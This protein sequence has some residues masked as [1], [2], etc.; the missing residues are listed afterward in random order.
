MG[1]DQVD[2]TDVSE[3]NWRV[4]PRPWS[5]GYEE[6]GE[7]IGA[8]LASIRKELGFENAEDFSAWIY[9][10]TCDVRN[11]VTTDFGGVDI[12]PPL[13][14][15]FEFPALGWE[16][17]SMYLIEGLAQALK[18]S[19]GTLFDEIALRASGRYREDGTEIPEDEQT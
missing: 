9:E 19:P 1:T 12:P 3:I 11:G 14:E 15:A 8:A 5:Y 4:T 2:K 10:A 17:A 7:Q 16:T 6:D 18:V 13:I